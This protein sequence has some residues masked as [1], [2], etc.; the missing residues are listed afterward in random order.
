MML[1]IHVPVNNEGTIVN[2]PQ[3]EVRLQPNDK[4]SLFLTDEHLKK[5]DSKLNV[6]DLVSFKATVCQVPPSPSSLL[7]CP[8]SP[9]I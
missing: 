3:Y 8:F 9:L 7:L 5:L 1:T 6:V 2:T 4:T